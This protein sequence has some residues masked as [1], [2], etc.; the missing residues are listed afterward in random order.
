VAKELQ[1]AD[2]SFY[3]FLKAT[4]DSVNLTM[5]SSIRIIRTP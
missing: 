5:A 3:R 4:A 1:K 2:R